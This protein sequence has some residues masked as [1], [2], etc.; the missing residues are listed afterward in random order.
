MGR[1]P[2]SKALHPSQLLLGGRPCRT[3]VFEFEHAR[4]TWS[5]RCSFH[6]TI[7]PVISNRHH[8]RRN[9]R[10]RRVVVGPATVV[11]VVPT[12][13]FV[14]AAPDHGFSA[15]PTKHSPATQRDNR[16]R[17]RTNRW[18]SRQQVAQAHSKRSGRNTRQRQSNDGALPTPAG[19]HWQTFLSSYCFLMICT[20]PDGPDPPV[21][22]V[23][24]LPRSGGFTLS[25]GLP[26]S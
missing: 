16:W 5:V 15:S 10:R 20:D 26:G 21:P 4:V 2:A 12:T 14:V 3:L 13:V 11:V 22:A 6:P 7:Q 24:P 25:G 17:S 8:R 19:H 18:R 23:T 9:P 1:H